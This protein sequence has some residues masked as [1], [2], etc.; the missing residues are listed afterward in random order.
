MHR[1]LN[2]P[3]DLIL[4]VCKD[5]RQLELLAF[6][7]YIMLVYKNATIFSVSAE[8]VKE[9]MRCKINE[10]ERLIAD[11]KQS[12]WFSY[13]ERRNSLRA[14]SMKSL[15][16]KLSRNNKVYRSD[17]C[18]KMTGEYISLG[19]MVKRLRGVIVML[20]IIQSSRG[21][22]PSGAKQEIA[23]YI[24]VYQMTFGKK[25]GLTQGTVSKLVSYLS[26]IGWLNK[27]HQYFEKVSK[28]R[29][30]SEEDRAE[31]KAN[32]HNC[33]L[34]VRS[35]SRYYCRVKVTDYNYYRCYG[36]GYQAA[37]RFEENFRHRIW[38]HSNLLKTSA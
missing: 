25:L 19:E 8:R 29:N 9:L 35:S 18:F 20:T 31:F 13:N 28:L 27:T 16:E 36:I 14:L 34:S 33:N 26:K 32:H 21:K 15:V 1:T 38:T 23:P 4:Q 22:S 30:S 7:V 37:D 2:I 3:V 12:K 10:A 5:K 17:F 24:M 11:A 6:R